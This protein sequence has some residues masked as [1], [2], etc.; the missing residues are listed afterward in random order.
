MTTF[1]LERSRHA[2]A[3]GPAHVSA[4]THVHTRAHWANG[5]SASLVLL[6]VNLR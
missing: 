6:R 3:L 4:S 1:L 2:R 5:T